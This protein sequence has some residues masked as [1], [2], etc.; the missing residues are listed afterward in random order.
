[1]CKMCIF[2]PKKVKPE[3]RAALGRDREVDTVERDFEPA[4]FCS[5]IKQRVKK[6]KIIIMSRV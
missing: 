5:S 4:A 3:K 2:K 6:M 1:M